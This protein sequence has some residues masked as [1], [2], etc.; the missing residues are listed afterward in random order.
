[1]PRIGGLVVKNS[2][3]FRTVLF[4]F[5]IILSSGFS[6]SAK[7]GVGNPCEARSQ[8]KSASVQEKT[9]T[10]FG[11]AIHYLEAGSGPNVVLL[12]GLGGDASGWAKTIDALS[13]KFHVFVPDQVGFGKSGKPLIQY[14]VGTL[15]DFLDG[16][17]KAVGIQRATV[18]GNSLG[19]WV[20]AAFALAH[21]EEVER[22]VLVDAA[23]FR[24]SVDPK[25]ARE[26][27]SSTRENI[28]RTMKL[29][30]YTQAIAEDTEE[31]DT[32]FTEKMTSG[33]GYTIHSFIESFSRGEDVLD[34][35]AS[36]I[37]QPTLIVWGKQDGLIAISTGE[38]Y[39]REIAGSQL[40]VID[41]CG[42]IPQIERPEEFNATLLAFLSK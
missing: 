13:G 38:R 39:K 24:D 9:V 41:K 31:I 34:G 27:D 8:D 2:L 25:V 33:D 10:V 3:R 21:P 36:G 19:G 11:V 5:A 22:V 40:V 37:K 23:G 6:A 26:L 4:A 1:M 15:V 42:H 20:T 18:I 29:A 14:R 16:F 35:K 12:H 17:Y 28:V 32:L 30:F 7:S